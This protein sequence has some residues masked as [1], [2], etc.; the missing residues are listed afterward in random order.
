MDFM[1]LPDKTIQAENTTTKAEP[2]EQDLST[3]VI[4]INNV[5]KAFVYLFVYA[6]RAYG[7]LECVELHKLLPNTF[8]SIKLISRADFVDA[9]AAY[10]CRTEIILENSTFERAAT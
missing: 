10:S 9:S 2:D 3:K 7:S 8:N 4:D 6:I 1:V 5:I